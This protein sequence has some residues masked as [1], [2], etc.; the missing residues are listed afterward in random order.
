[1]PWSLFTPSRKWIDITGQVSKTL[2]AGTLRMQ[3]DGHTRR[4]EFDGLTFAESG[5][6]TFLPGLA[7]GDR[8][9]FVFYNVAQGVTGH[10]RVTPVGNLMAY[11]WTAGTQINGQLSWSTEGEA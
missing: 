1:M 5:S 11:N 6:G 9:A 7:P 4:V 10:A 2:T 8:P 3:R